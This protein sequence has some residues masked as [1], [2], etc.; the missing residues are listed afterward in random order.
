[1]IGWFFSQNVV[2]YMRINFNLHSKITLKDYAVYRK[3]KM[4]FLSICY[5]KMSTFNAEEMDKNTN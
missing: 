4:M 2:S 1:M 3:N 5:D